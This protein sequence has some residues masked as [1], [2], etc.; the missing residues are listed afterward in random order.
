MGY[1][2]SP[3]LFTDITRFITSFCRG[4]NILLIMYIDDILILGK[5]EEDCAQK[6]DFVVQ[7]LKNLG[8]LINFEKSSLKPSQKVGSLCL[9]FYILLYVISTRSPIWGWSGI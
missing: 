4:K 5:S 2:K 6:V 3:G 8:F 1:T 9:K 7:L